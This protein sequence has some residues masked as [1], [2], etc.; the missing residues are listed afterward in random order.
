MRQNKINV[1]AVRNGVGGGETPFTWIPI[2][3]KTIICLPDKSH[4]YLNA[5]NQI[6]IVERIW[7][8]IP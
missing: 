6:K 7:L 1:M 2:N 5:K 4:T 3:P 8:K